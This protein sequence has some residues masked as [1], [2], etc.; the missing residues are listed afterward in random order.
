[1]SV[2]AFKVHATIITKATVKHYLVGCLIKN[3]KTAT[4][5]KHI[6]YYDPSTSHKNTELNKNIS[7]RR[8][9]KENKARASII[10][11]L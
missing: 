1:M 2:F 11:S 6:G 9:R 7:D 4:T 10:V 3:V 8:S 5:R